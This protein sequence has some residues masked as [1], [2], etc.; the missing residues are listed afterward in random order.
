MKHGM[1][2]DNCRVWSETPLQTLLLKQC[3]SSVMAYHATSGRDL[4][5]SAYWPRQ[6]VAQPYDAAAPALAETDLA[7]LAAKFTSSSGP[8]LS[9]D[10]AVDLALQMVLHAIVEQ[11]CVSTS[12][13]GAAIA[14]YHG[15][16]L[17][18]RAS[19]GSTAPPL[20]SRLDL[21]AG[22]SGECL[23]TG[24]TQLC[25]D[26]RTD[27]RVDFELCSR[28][29]VHSVAV[30]PVSR[31]G[32]MMGIFEVLSPRPSAFGE[33]EIAGLGVLAHRILKNLEIAASLTV[34]PARESLLAAPNGASDGLLAG[35]GHAAEVG[36]RWTDMVTW[37]LGMVVL[38]CAG[39]VSMR[40]VR[41]FTW[42]KA[43]FHS[44]S[45]HSPSMRVKA[46]A[47]ETDRS[48][49]TANGNSDAAVGTPPGSSPA[50]SASLSGVRDRTEM[51]DPTQ[52]PRLRPQEGS[53]RVYENGK[54]VYHAPP[55]SQEASSAPRRSAARTSSPQLQDV[56]ELSPSA[57]ESSLTYRVEP[58]YPEDARVEGLQGAV[59]LEV[60][61]RPEGSVEQIN[62]ISGEPVLAN[63]AM[64]A[65]K[66]WR[67]K[68][69][70]VNG[71]AAEMQTTITLNFRLPS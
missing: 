27:L 49:S 47:A 14:L 57:A 13:T 25:N 19:H 40:V 55:S 69:R 48:A 41:H 42:Q 8:S 35:G 43:A 22:L 36:R 56:L 24:N 21:G 1:S 52:R 59:V 65:V 28:L 9:L 16:E 66:Q 23:R 71:Q 15:G 7:E 62:V 30:L 17:V 5:Q 39:W 37:V 58:E 26:V 63:A 54:E 34:A 2:I 46:V 11:A 20:G 44:P 67:F 61:I 29:G 50:L 64:A 68:P 53:L 18:C 60:H 32:E 10:L 33:A 45:I 4:S 70:Q 3:A 51:P 6:P 31:A 12:A 38:V